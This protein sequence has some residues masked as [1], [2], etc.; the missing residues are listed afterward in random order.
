MKCLEN[1]R[2]GVL[3]AHV[4]TSTRHTPRPRDQVLHNH[5]SLAHISGRVNVLDAHFDAEATERSS[6]SGVIT[7]KHEL[8]RQ[9]TQ[10]QDPFR[11]YRRC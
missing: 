5:S 2:A 6:A 10:W 8:M 7:A 11:N 4:K 1:A 3:M 9:A